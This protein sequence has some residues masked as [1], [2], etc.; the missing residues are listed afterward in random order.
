[1]VS[2]NHRSQSIADSNYIQIQFRLTLCPRRMILHSQGRILAGHPLAI[3][4]FKNPRNGIRAGQSTMK[5]VNY[6][7]HS[8]RD[9]YELPDRTSVSIPWLLV[10]ERY[11]RS[12][13]R[14]VSQT[15]NLVALKRKKKRNL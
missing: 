5:V 15:S 11:S 1:M 12:W 4:L 14:R 8:N 2:L 13:S 7:M 6:I 10:H 9:T 3:L